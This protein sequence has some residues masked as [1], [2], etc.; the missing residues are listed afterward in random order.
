MLELLP[1]LAPILAIDILNPVLFAV[2]IY[3]SGTTRPVLN[4]SALLL[5]GFLVVDAISLDRPGAWE[6]LHCS[7]ISPII[8]GCLRGGETAAYT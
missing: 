3:A 4:S 2:L 5:G 7:T 8:Y 6:T 1:R